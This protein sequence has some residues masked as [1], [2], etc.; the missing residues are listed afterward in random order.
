[1]NRMIELGFTDDLWS[2]TA[3]R[4]TPKIIR[5]T[6]LYHKIHPTAQPDDKP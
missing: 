5:K 6:Q 4:R 3:G 2:A 1:M